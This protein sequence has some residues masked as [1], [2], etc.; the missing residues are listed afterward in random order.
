MNAPSRVQL[1]VSSEG[2][3]L[4]AEA[5]LTDGDLARAAG[6]SAA[7]LVRLVHLGLIE[8]AAPG[9][10]EFTA[11]SAERL[12]RMLRLHDDLEVNLIGAAVIVDL[13]ERLDRLESDL[14]RLRDQGQGRG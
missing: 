3:P 9:G 13:L 7:T 10:N 6:I 2:G 1:R 14:T 8:P 12:R 4:R 5:R 11:A